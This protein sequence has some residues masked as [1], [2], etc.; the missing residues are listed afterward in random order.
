[1]HGF[2]RLHYESEYVSNN[3]S[4]LISIDRLHTY[5]FTIV[6]FLIIVLFYNDFVF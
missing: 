5:I 4:V 6:T 2:T 3:V 1:M